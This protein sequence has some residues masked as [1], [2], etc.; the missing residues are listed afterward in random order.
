MNIA[1]TSRWS[2]FRDLELL[3]IRGVVA[4]A[5]GTIAMDA[6]WYRRYR[7]GGGA[8]SAVAWEFDAQATDFDGAPAPAKVG[9]RIAEAVGIDLPD[10]SVSTT[11][12]VVHWATGLS[13]GVAAAT[14]HRLPRV[15][16]ITAGDVAGLGAFSMSYVVLP[17][18]NIYKSITEYDAATLAKD[19]SAHLVFGAA[20][21]LAT[22][23]IRSRS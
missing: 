23:A 1:D 11:N 10:S 16:G 6:L 22:R 20:A 21:G 5:I 4:G 9:K 13:W 14:L 3:L 17:K 7:R 15:G 18:L 12:N 19:L 8:A 2:P